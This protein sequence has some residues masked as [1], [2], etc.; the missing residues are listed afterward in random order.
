[1][2]VRVAGARVGRLATVTPAARPH[3]VP[4]C[5]AL[6]DDAIYTAVDAKPKTTLALQRLTNIRA[7]PAA[8]LLVD[9]YADDWAELWWVRVDGSARIVES[10]AEAA[11][12]I[13]ALQEKYEQYRQLPP[14]GAVLAVAIE[15]WRGWSYD[16]PRPHGTE[17]TRY[18]T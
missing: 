1:M 7:H 17:E 4:C 11:A 14:A 15:A 5:F 16:D 10:D 8:T 3:V 9:H 2:R 6:M 13:A 12:A 18:P